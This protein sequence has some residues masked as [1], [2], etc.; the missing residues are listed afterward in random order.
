MKPDWIVTQD[1]LPDEGKE[2][3]V[4]HKVEPGRYLPVR[5]AQFREGKWYSESQQL[6]P[7]SH[8]MPVPEPPA[9]RK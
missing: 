8:W 7:P 9:I 2:V 6:W 3:L 5:I 1:S 4:A